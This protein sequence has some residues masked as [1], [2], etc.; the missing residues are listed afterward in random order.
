MRVHEDL[1]ND[2]VE[3]LIGRMQHSIRTCPFP[4]DRCVYCDRDARCITLLR[5]LIALRRKSSGL[6]E[7]A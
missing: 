7:A 4:Q 2:D 6:S 5:E 3:Q 1:N